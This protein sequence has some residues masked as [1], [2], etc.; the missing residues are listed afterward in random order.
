MK[1]VMRDTWLLFGRSM[2]GSLRSPGMIISGLFQPICYVLL[3]APLL[4][5]LASAPG[6]PPGSGL[7]VFT[8]GILVLMA[9]LSAAFVGFGMISDLRSGVIERLRVTPASR[10]ALL[11]GNVIRDVL[12]LAIQ[13]IILLLLAWPL[14]LQAHLGGVIIALGLL[15]MVGLLMAGFSYG[16]ALAVKNENALAG[17]INTLALPLLLLSGVM[18]PLAIAPDW[19]RGIATLNPFYHAVE[20]IRAL[21]NG[22]F[23]ADA[24]LISFISMGI[25]AA[26]CLKWASSAFKQATA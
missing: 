13:S 24:I 10:M 5:G 1:K 21:F 26:L 15:I 6:F 2:T 16:V 11:L 4:N 8:P 17:M 14:G 3:F 9:I 22:N 12:V 19:I 25:L 7:S 20:A 23:G 18:L